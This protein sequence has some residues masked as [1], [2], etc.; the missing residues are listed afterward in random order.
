MSRLTGIYLYYGTR[1]QKAILI[2]I[3]AKIIVNDDRFITITSDWMGSTRLKPHSRHIT[4][5]Y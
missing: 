5:M 2:K 1:L 3:M 4:D